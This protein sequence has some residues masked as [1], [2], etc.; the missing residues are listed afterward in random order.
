MFDVFEEVER[1]GETPKKGA[2]KQ[3]VRAQ[4]II[5]ITPK[6]PGHVLMVEME[7]SCRCVACFY[8]PAVYFSSL[9]V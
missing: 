7:V 5:F 2:G 3:L 9:S 4:A 6:P 1:K 8:P